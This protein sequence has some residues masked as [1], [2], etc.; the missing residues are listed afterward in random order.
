MQAISRLAER[1]S[2]SQVGRFRGVSRHYIVVFVY[3][4]TGDIYLKIPKTWP[5]LF[6]ELISLLAVV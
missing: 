1:L 4:T 2:A 3:I 5:I 6:K